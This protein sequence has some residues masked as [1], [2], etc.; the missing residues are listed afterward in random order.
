MSYEINIHFNLIND[1]Q[2]ELVKASKAT[3]NIIPTLKHLDIDDKPPNRFSRLRI[4]NMGLS[5][6]VVDEMVNTNDVT[7]VWEKIEPYIASHYFCEID[8]A[9]DCF[10]FN[11]TN[12]SLDAEVR[13]LKIHFYGPKYG[14]N[15]FEYKSY[16]PIRLCFSNTK[17]FQVQRSLI[18]FTQRTAE[19]GLDTTNGLNMIAKIGRNYDVISNIS[20]QLILHL[21]P[22]TLLVSTD[23]DVHPMMAHSIYHSNKR[24]YVED[25][26]KIARLHKEGGIYLY[27]VTPSDPAFVSPRNFPQDYGY[28]RSLYLSEVKDELI[29]EFE[30]MVE[31]IYNNPDGI[32]LT[33]GEIDNCFGEL[34][35]TEVSQLN[36]CYYLSVYD[37]PFEYIEEPYLSLYKHIKKM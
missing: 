33:D 15:G 9:F 2:L 1:S 10:V 31:D 23:L 24:Q 13:P 4:Y 21:N 12:K 35:S 32:N 28:L 16:G 34:I 36:G 22:K 25:L 27:D 18:D 37:A 19:C 29:K 5:K 14:W 26:R 17:V 20:K 6:V 11:N 3:L 30:C 7:V 8:S